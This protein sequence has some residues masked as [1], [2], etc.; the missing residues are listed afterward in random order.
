MA[1][2]QIQRG[3]LYVQTCPAGPLPFP[4][5]TPF[6]KRV[7]FLPPKPTLL[8]PCKPYPIMLGPKSQTQTQILTQTQTQKSKTQISDLGFSLLK[9]QT[10]TQVQTQKSK[11]QKFQI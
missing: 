1:T 5:P 7:F 4:E 8:G 10:Q 6:N 11:T 2:S 3:F 9:S